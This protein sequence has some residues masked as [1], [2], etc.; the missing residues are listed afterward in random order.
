MEIRVNF[1]PIIVSLFVILCLSDWTGHHCNGVLGTRIDDGGTMFMEEVGENE[2]I[3]IETDFEPEKP[4]SN[5]IHELQRHV[6]ETS[7]AQ[8]SSSPKLNLGTTWGSEEN[9]S[10]DGDDE[11]DEEYYDLDQTSEEEMDEEYGGNANIQP[12]P[13]MPTRVIPTLLSPSFED[14]GSRIEGTRTIPNPTSATQILPT[15]PLVLSSNVPNS[16]AHYDVSTILTH[17]QIYT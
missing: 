10:G 14:S 3:P 16:I 17:F 8:Q 12:T 7:D 4:N 15:K 5:A 6:R 13:I 1:G 11:E 2:I 9:G